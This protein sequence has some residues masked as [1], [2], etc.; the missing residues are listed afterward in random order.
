MLPD[1]ENHFDYIVLLHVSV[2]RSLNF[3]FKVTS[4]LLL[5]ITS[6]SGPDTIR[7]SLKWLETACITYI[8]RNIIM[9]GINI[10]LSGIRKM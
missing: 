9:L 5:S 10:T 6:L 7:G 2:G 8:G 3:Q 4:P 1:T